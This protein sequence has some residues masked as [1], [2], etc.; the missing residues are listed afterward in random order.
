[1]QL[2]DTTM[3]VLKNFSSINENIVI[4]PGVELKT[5]SEAK[6]I[7]GKATVDTPFEQMIGIYQ[8][9]DF[10]STLSLCD[11][12]SLKFVSEPSSVLIGDTTGVSQAK[13]YFSN[14]E[15]LTK[16]TRDIVMPTPEVE[17]ELSGANL[18][19]IKKAASVLGHREVVVTSEDD[20]IRLTVMD[21]SNSTANTFSIDI[22]GSF[23]STDFMFVWA[24]ENFRMVPG[25]YRVELSSKLISHFENL[26]SPIE[27]WIALEKNS[28]YGV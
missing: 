11:D 16:P 6:N 7:I 28:K 23:E 10:I 20:L 15:A 27:Y 12:P 2:S 3:T 26:H 25:D 24:I 22:A 17:F 14:P 1:M 4:E 9:S 13:Y 19:K 8:L 5:I 18:E 21:T